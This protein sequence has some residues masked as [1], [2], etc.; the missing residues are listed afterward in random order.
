MT[1]YW[2]EHYRSARQA[3][4]KWLDEG[5]IRNF[6]ARYQGVESCGVAFSDMFA[7]KN[8]G[9]AIVKVVPD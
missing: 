6:E 7:G 9:K 2:V 5:K 3:L 4:V 1:H 8:F